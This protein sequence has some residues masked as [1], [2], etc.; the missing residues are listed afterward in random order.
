MTRK[1]PT[2]F[3]FRMPQKKNGYITGLHG[4]HQMELQRATLMTDATGNSPQSQQLW[5]KSSLIH[6]T[7]KGTYMRLLAF[8]GT[9]PEKA[10]TIVQTHIRSPLCTCDVSECVLLRKKGNNWR[11][12]LSPLGVLSAGDWLP[13]PLFILIHHKRR[14]ENGGMCMSHYPFSLQCMGSR[15]WWMCVHRRGTV[16]KEKLNNGKNAPPLRPGAPNELQTCQLGMLQLR[17]I[18]WQKITRRVQCSRELCNY[19][20]TGN[21]FECGEAIH[22]SSGQFF[23]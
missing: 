23:F 7:A 13:H 15:C 12:S 19:N 9:Y 16:I 2:R 14:G 4:E 18:Y 11:D 6:N 22:K 21:S 8:I 5:S 1:N 20:G 10:H 3:I 17:E